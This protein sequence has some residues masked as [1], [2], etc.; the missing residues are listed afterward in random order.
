MD[1][2]PNSEEAVEVLQQLGLKEYEAKC[3][4]GLTRLNMSTAKNSAVLPMSPVPEYTTRYVF[5]RHRG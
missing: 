4:V 2:D 3:F 1:A 5:L